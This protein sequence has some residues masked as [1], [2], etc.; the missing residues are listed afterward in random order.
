L[1]LVC[2][3]KPSPAPSSSALLADHVFDTLPN[4][5]VEYVAIAPGVESDMGHGDQWPPTS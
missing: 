3:L 4:T 1:A 5:D 2:S